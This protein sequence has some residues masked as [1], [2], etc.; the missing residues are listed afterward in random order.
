MSKDHKSTV[1]P[2]EQINHLSPVYPSHHGNDESKS[3]SLLLIDAVSSSGYWRW[4]N[5]ENRN[6]QLAE[7][8][9][10]IFKLINFCEVLEKIVLEYL[11]DDQIENN[12]EDEFPRD[13]CRDLERWLKAAWSRDFKWPENKQFLNVPYEDEKLQQM[14]QLL[15]NEKQYTS[16]SSVRQI[17]LPQILYIFPQA[18][19]NI[20]DGYLG[21]DEK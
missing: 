21:E 15:V 19:I 6:S 14:T 5:I 4:S 16:Q 13:P 8:I 20:I 17:I 1:L 2:F 10:L 7:Q 11:I 9:P 18:L 3:I 12:Q